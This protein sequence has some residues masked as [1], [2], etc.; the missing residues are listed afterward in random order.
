MQF[1]TIT[2][3]GIGLIGGSIAYGLKEKKL[4]DKII[5]IDTQHDN[6]KIAQQNKIIDVSLSEINQEALNVDVVLI[7]TPVMMIENVLKSIS[8]FHLSPNTVVTDVGSTKRG[9]LKAYQKY[10][11]HHFAYCVA[12]HPVAGCEKSGADNIIPNLFNQ[13]KVILCPHV[14]Q[15]EKSVD[16]IQ[17]LWESLGAK[18]Y[19]MQAERHDQIFAMTSHFP[20]VLAYAFMNQL[21]ESELKDQYL[22]FAGTGFRDFTR[23]AGSDPEMWSGICVENQDFLLELLE[24]YFQELK[25]MKNLLENKD[26]DQ[27]KTYFSTSQQVR[28]AWE[29]TK[30]QL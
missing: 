23:I 29:N 22:T 7:A 11:P 30:S 3:I 12:G 21:N 10:L 15:E 17:I 13:Q 24:Q 5:G 4:V 26:K 18:I 27:L 9:V 25:I 2:I 20:H 28:Q 19:K 8:Q 16:K 6:L 14:E 1:K